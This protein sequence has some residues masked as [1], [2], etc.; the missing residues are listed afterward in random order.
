M[1]FYSIDL[2][3]ENERIM[4]YLRDAEEV[5][6]KIIDNTE[7]VDEYKLKIKHQLL[8]LRVFMSKVEMGL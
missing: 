7:I 5:F 3:Y 1:S 8:E 6:E 2:D 4:R